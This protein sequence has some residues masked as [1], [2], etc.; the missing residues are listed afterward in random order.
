MNGI[1]ARIWA[2]L[3][4]HVPPEIHDFWDDDEDDE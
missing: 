4:Q 3:E 2:W 1:W